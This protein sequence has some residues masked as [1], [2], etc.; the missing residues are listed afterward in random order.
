MAM[1]TIRS[2]YALDVETMQVLK[3]IANKWKLSKSEAL[4]R[5]IRAGR[6]AEAARPMI[7]PHTGFFIVDGQAV[8]PSATP[9]W[10]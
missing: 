4:R 9:A 1:S 8:Q 2:T 5:V 6:R 10:P 3:R 7:Y